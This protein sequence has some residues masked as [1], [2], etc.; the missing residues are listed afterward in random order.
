MIEAENL[1]PPLAEIRRHAGVEGFRAAFRYTGE[2]TLTLIRL[3][4]AGHGL[5]LLPEGV[6]PAG[7][8]AVPVSVPRVVHRVEL[9]HG[10]LREL[11]PAAELAAILSPR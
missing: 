5:T 2:D 8:S 6:L 10:T 4:T 3:A 1:A 11:S 9:I 7:V